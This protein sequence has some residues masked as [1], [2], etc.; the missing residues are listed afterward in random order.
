MTVL[1]KGKFGHR[2]AQREEETKTWRVPCEKG[3]GQ[4]G[5][6]STSQGMPKI[7]GKPPE[8]GRGKELSLQVSEEHDDPTDNWLSEF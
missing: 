8:T 1:T 3:I 6:A 2:H 4:L 5:A 7:I